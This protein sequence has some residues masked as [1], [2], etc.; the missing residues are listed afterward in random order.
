MMT[1]N[2]I[3]TEVDYKVFIKKKNL[4]FIFNTSCEIIKFYILQ[5]LG[6]NIHSESN[7]VGK[8]SKLPT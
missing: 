4:T 5:F 7:I 3:I 1:L 8:A 6:L 2:N